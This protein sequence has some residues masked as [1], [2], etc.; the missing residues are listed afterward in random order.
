MRLPIGDNISPISHRLATIHL[1]QTRTT[2]RRH[3]VP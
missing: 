2:D 3:I 1:W